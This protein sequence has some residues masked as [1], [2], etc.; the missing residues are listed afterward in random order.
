M[1]GRRVTISYIS[2]KVG[3]RRFISYIGGHHTVEKI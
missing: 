1:A 2:V 3:W